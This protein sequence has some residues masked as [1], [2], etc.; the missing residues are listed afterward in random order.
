MSII[1][2]VNE[3]P[4]NDIIGKTTVFYGK[5]ASGKTTMIQDIM[6][7][8]RDRIYMSIIVSPSEPQNHNFSQKDP[9]CDKGVNVPKSCIWSDLNMTKLQEL[10]KRQQAISAS[11]DYAQK[12]RHLTDVINEYKG[13]PN[14]L[15]KILDAL[16]GKEGLTR[17]QCEQIKI[18]AIQKF[19]QNN[20]KQIVAYFEQIKV[21]KN[22]ILYKTV[23]GVG[24]NPN[25]LIVIDDG[26]EFLKTFVN[27]ELFTQLVT[28]SRHFN[29]TVLLCC[30][31][32][33]EIPARK[34]NMIS[35]AFLMEVN[36]ANSFINRAGV[37]I[38]KE[39]VKEIRRYL[40]TIFAKGSYAKLAVIDGY[41]YIYEADVHEYFICCSQEFYD[42]ATRISKKDDEVL[43]DANNK[44][45]SIF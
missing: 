41:A 16:D 1:S 40:P 26:T 10:I 12:L 25:V 2:E 20:K 44:Y 30:H 11:Y 33:V 18:R 4:L 9:Y 28:K 36:A 27:T 35:N 13:T 8:L 34:R 45:F 32:E 17:K 15:H 3:L 5:T 22:A 42:Y 7:S 23:K 19:I 14:R 37:P 21:E 39:S 6:H 31:S 24:M 38:D 29:I 43:T